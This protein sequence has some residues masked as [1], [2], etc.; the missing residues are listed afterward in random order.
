MMKRRQFLG[1]AAAVVPAVTWSKLAQGGLVDL[2]DI[3]SR[4][5][6]PIEVVYKTPHGKPNGLDITR[7]GMW[8]MDQGPENYISLIDPKD[9]RLIRE[10]MPKNVRAASGIGIDDDGTMWIGSTY[11]RMIVHIDPKSGNTIAAYQTPGAGLI[12]RV[13][14]DPPGRSTNLKPAYPPTEPPRQRPANEPARLPDGQVSLDADVAPAGTGAHCILPKGDALYV[15]V[16]PARAIFTINKKTW[17][18]TDMWQ[19]AGNRSHDMTWADAGKTKLWASDSNLNAFYLHDMRTGAILEKLQL[20]TDSPV[21]HGAKIWNGHM[22]FCDDVGW[23]C[24]F[25]MPA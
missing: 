6:S 9:G 19:A 24:R 21:I 18:V 25:K 10:F 22:Y 4:D 2:S 15:A 16:P 1:T 8:V 23:M 14:G 13:E 5:T 7:E 12:Y 11:N 3:R 20:P 17:R